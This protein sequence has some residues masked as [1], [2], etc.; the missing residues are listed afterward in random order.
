MNRFPAKKIFELEDAVAPQ[1]FAVREGEIYYFDK[2]NKHEG[3]FCRKG[4]D[5]TQTLVE[6]GEGQGILSVDG[7]IYLIDIDDKTKIYK[8][9]EEGNWD[10]AVELDGTYFDFKISET[11]SCVCLGNINSKTQ[12]KILNFEGKELV[13]FEPANILFGSSICLYKDYIYMGSIDNSNKFKLLKMNY[14]GNVENS[15]DIKID[16]SGRLIS[17]IFI[18]DDYAFLLIEGKRDSLAVINMKVGSAKEIIPEEL[19]I[20]NIIDFN[21]YNDSIYLLD[22]RTIHMWDTRDIINMKTNRHLIDIKIDYDYILYKYLMYSQGIKEQIFSGFIYSL[23]IA[24][25]IFLFTYERIE[26]YMKEVSPVLVCF[27]MFCLLNYMVVSI[28]NI[29]IITKKEK[30]IEYLLS[31]YRGYRISDILLVPVYMGIVAAATVSFALLPGSNIT[32]V[33]CAFSVTFVLFYLLNRTAGNRIKKMN[34]D[35]VI[36]LLQ[37]DD[38]ETIGYI[39]QV[40]NNIKSRKVN[41]L[42]IEIISDKRVDRGIVSR[43]TRSRENILKHNIAVEVEENKIITILDFSDRDIKYSHFS[44]IM[45]YICFVKS[46]VDIKEIQFL[47]TD[48]PY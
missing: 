3:R 19:K 1:L 5:G 47:F 24:L 21:L 7:S 8:L 42:C 23:I 22:S 15:W 18:F 29:F 27:Y 41:R 17:K 16:S 34:R 45:D 14:L 32:T 36:E 39:K 37:D 30:R 44:I 11:G 25:A 26:I 33:L 20:K 6:I 28:R 40:V 4:T 9:N 13:A 35:I 12:L 43:W 38:V 31:L 46:R 2:I 10:N 48:K